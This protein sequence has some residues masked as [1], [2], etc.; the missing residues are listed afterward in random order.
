MVKRG[1]PPV[2]RNCPKCGAELTA[3]QMQAHQCAGQPTKPEAGTLRKERTYER[4]D[5]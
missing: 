3:R 4:I 1:R 2:L 5:D